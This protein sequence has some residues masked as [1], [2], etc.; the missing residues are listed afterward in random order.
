VVADNALRELLGR[1]LAWEDAHVGF[2][3]AVANISPEHR[4]L[5]PPGCPWSAWQLVEHLR[6]AQWDILDFCRNPHYEEKRWP[7]D[8]WPASPE[9]PSSDAWEVSI[10]QVL[11]DRRE[12]QELAAN[13]DVDLGARIPHGSGQTYLRELALVAD[14]NAYHVGQLILLRRLLG[15]WP[16]A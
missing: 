6:L 2:E 13:P 1:L 7:N 9:P 12:L 4:G 16:S 10:R 11:D 14:H 5:Q 3:A 8:Y 15:I